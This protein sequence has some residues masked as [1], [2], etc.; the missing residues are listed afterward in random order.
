MAKGCLLGIDIGTNCNQAHAPLHP[1]SG[2]RLSDV[3]VAAPGDGNPRT[4]AVRRL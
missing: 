2:L 1:G 3:F 4:I